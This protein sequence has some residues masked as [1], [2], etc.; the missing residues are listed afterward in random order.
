MHMK[1]LGLV[2]NLV[3]PFTTIIEEYSNFYL[4]DFKWITESL[5]N[6]YE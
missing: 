1:A 3:F 5:D 2:N 6:F 4:G